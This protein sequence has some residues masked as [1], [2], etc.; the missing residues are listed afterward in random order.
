[1]SQQ[2]TKDLTGDQL[3]EIKFESTFDFYG[4]YKAMGFK[5]EVS[6]VKNVKGKDCYEV[7]FSNAS[8]NR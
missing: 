5:A 4:K 3:E 8:G 2:G 6:G 1:V 7:S